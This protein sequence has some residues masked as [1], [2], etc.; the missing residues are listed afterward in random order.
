MNIHLRNAK[1]AHSRAKA[2]ADKAK[3][4]NREMNAEELTAFD[5]AMAEFESE[6]QLGEA[7]LAREQ[8]LAA[9]D[10]AVAGIEPPAPVASASLP[11]GAGTPPVVSVGLPN[12]LA[13]RAL[14]FKSANHYMHDVLRASLG[15]GLSPEL[16]RVKTALDSVKAASGAATFNGEDGGFI[17]APPEYSD[18][19]YARA[20]DQLPFLDQVEKVYVK[21]NSWICRSLKDADKSS[22]AYRHGGIVVYLVDEGDSITSSKPKFRLD[23][24]KLHKMGALVYAT[25]EEIDDAPGFGDSMMNNVAVAFANEITEYCLWGTGVGQPQGILQSDACVSI[26]KESAQA[27]NTLLTANVLKMWA[28]M[29]SAGRGKCMWLYNADLFTHLVGLVVDT[30]AG[31]TFP[32]YMPPGGLAD[33]PHGRIMGRPAF[34]TEHM[35]ALSTA[36]DLSLVDPSPYKLVTKGAAIPEMAVSM[37]FKFDS[38]EQAF[39]FTY[40]LDGRLPWDTYLTPRK[41]TTYRSAAVKLGAR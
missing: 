17:V 3:A 1:A 23:T 41:G 9:A 12:L 36:G 32:V 19:I 8:K 38:H 13:D 40:R 22:S 15:Q 10:A 25:Q 35:P 20:V 4:E 26:T 14:G 18:M 21:G 28:A 30:G 5:A 39:R 29:W 33:A 11:V 7:M 16:T 24:L 2:L 6:K 27:A 37:H 31:V 34:E